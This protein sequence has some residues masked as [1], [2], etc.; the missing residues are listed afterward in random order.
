MMSCKEATHLMSED[1]ERPLSRRERVALRLH[2]MMCSGCRNFRVQIGFLRT[3][4]R[5]RSG[6]G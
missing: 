2:L 3:A 5:R 1:L 4:I 6:R